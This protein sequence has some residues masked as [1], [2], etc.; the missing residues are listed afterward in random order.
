METTLIYEIIGYVASLLVAVSLMMSNIIQ[1]RIVNLIGSATFSLYGILIGSI[2]VAAMNGFIVL[3]N[4]YYLT[5]IYSAV[6]YFK[7]LKVTSDSEYLKTFL[8]FYKDQISVFQPDFNSGSREDGLNIFVLRDMIPAGLLV[9]TINQN[10]VLKVELDF[11]VPQYRDFRVG[12]FLFEENRS[13]F[14]ERGI[15]EIVASPGNKRH[16][17][18]L[19]EMNFDFSSKEGSDELYR[20]KI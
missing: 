14:K 2:P 1:L 20:L 9:G 11:V 13:F 7:I 5:Q 10:G 4:I 16:N 19:E 3:I 15:Q 8:N 6:E 17:E 18:Y 12:T